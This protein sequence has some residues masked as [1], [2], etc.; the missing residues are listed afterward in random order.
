MNRLVLLSLLFVPFSVLGI[1]DM[2]NANYS[3][4]WTDLDVPGSGYSMKIVRTYNSRTLFNGIFGFGWCSEFETTL[5]IT[6][7][8][9]LRVTECGAGAEV[10]YSPTTLTAKEIA[11]SAD[12]II[13]KMKLEKGQGRT[14]AFY[15]D[16]R[17]KFLNKDGV[18][19]EYATKYGISTPPREGLK[20]MANGKEVEHFIFSK[21]HYT[22]N[23]ADGTSQRFNLQGRITHFYD[24]N[25]NVLK[26]EYEKEILTA[27]VDNNGRRFSFKYHPN[28]KVR[29]IVGPSGLKA[30]YKYKDLDDLSWVKNGWGNIYTFEYDTG[31]NL[32]KVTW[33]DKTFIKL[34]YDQKRDWVMSFTDRDKCKESYKY[35]DSPEDPKNHYWST[36]KKVCNGKVLADNRYEF[37]HKKGPNGQVYLQRVLTEINGESTEITYHE[38][39]GKPTSIRKNKNRVAFDYYPN[40]LV[41]VKASARSRQSF[42]YEPESKRV[43]K[44]TTELYNEK[45]VR[46][47]TKWTQFKYDIRF[48]LTFAENSDG[49][50]ISMTYD[51]RGRIETMVDQ[52]KKVVK[53]DYDDKIGKPSVVTR[54]GLGTIKVS[55]KSDGTIKAV[56]SKEGPTVALQVA[57]TFNNLLDIISPATAEL[58]IL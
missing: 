20:Y 29:E 10:T 8:G 2:K 21:N 24:K 19:D 1:V 28:K 7:E 39:F 52:A 37:W 14:E 18:R 12:Q 3:E 27:V 4:T 22:R 13:A 58:F 25:G 11:K 49:Q 53:I 55:Y 51:K 30:E 15:R 50:K 45:A 40:G 16:L 42:L 54:P 35:E 36:V 5:N 34:E 6:A 46:V 41:K 56:D 38:L 9:N 48:N 47:S 26:F 23:F 32:T 43:S 44:V 57:S 33:P 31:H 17:E